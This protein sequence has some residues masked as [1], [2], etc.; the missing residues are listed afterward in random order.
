MALDTTALRHR[1]LNYFRLHHHQLY[2]ASPVVALK[3]PTLLFTNAGMNQ[4]KD[5]FLGRSTPPH[6]SVATCQVCMRAGGKHNDLDNVGHT[7]RHLTLFEMLGNFSFGDYSK[8]QAIDFAW[9]VATEVFE[10]DQK[11]IYPTVFEEDDEAHQLWLAHV[12]QNR[13]TRMGRAENFW[14]MG[15]AGPCGPCSELLYDRGPAFGSAQSP[16]DDKSGERFMEFWNL[17]FMQSKLEVDGTVTPLATPMIDTG[18]GL[19]RIAMLKLGVDSV[20]ETD[21][22]RALIKR[23]ESIAH[24]PYGF[25]ETFDSAMRVIADHCR[26]ISFCIADGAFPANIEQG[27]VVRKLIRRAMRYGKVLGLKDPFL[28]RVLPLVAELMG[29][30]YPKLISTQDEICR[31]VTQEERSFLRTLAKGERQFDDVAKTALKEKR[32][33]SG[34]EIFTLKD[35]HGLPFEEIAYLAEDAGLTLDEVS[36]KALDQAAKELAQKSAKQANQRVDDQTKIWNRLFETAGATPFC[37]YK[38]LQIETS[39][40]GIAVKGALQD[41]LLAGQEALIALNESPFYAESGGQVGDR[42]E[43]IAKEG[44]FLVCDTQVIDQIIVHR[45]AVVSGKLTIG[46]SLTACVDQE[47]RRGAS[48]HHTATHLLDWALGSV[49]NSPIEQSGSL[50]QSNRLRYD[51]RWPRAITCDEIAKVEALVNEAIAGDAPI[52]IDQITLEQ[53][54]QDPT[55]H[56]Q[57]GDKYGQ[58]VRLVT[59]GE[60]KCLCCGTHAETSSQLLSFRILKEQSVGSGYRRIEA[61]AGRAAQALIKQRETQLQEMANRLQSSPE[62][63]LKRLEGLLQES[64]KLKKELQLLKGERLKSQS[65]IYLERAAQVQLPGGDRSFQLVIERVDE[66]DLKALADRIVQRSAL[67]ILIHNQFER[68]LVLIRLSPD[69]AKMNL[70]AE[71]LW[72]HFQNAGF[73]GKGGLDLAQ[74][75]GPASAVEGALKAMKEAM[76]L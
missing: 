26:S 43:I 37:G 58:I 18:A 40:L 68:A 17:V 39:L 2:P 47:H 5:H 60:S 32:A 15:A 20:F 71:M 27:Y 48:L 42:G 53:A 45:G 38:T 62:Q 51:I 23:V 61:L 19:E 33:L 75:A 4:F 44:H 6:K 66:S 63:A 46:D 28:Q 72:T 59:A 14:T 65:L 57:F 34:H 54:R 13:I 56:Q 41:E 11:R 67:A 3:D 24:R 12:P 50:V 73:R 1:F 29:I 64:G 10:F 69:V 8:R 21:I 36:Y 74:G 16:L 9:Q 76:G 35:T 55:I 49:L 22:L 30:D 7:K 25:D 31:I 70:R 52:F